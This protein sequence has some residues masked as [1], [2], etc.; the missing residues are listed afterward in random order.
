ME[1]SI[2]PSSKNAILELRVRQNISQLDAV[3]IFE[4]VFQRKIDVQHIPVDALQAKLNSF[5][6]S[7]QKSF[8]GLMKCV[9]S[10]DRIDMKKVLS[11]FPVELI[12]VKDLAILKLKISYVLIIF[13]AQF[14]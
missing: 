9:T 12:S 4:K 5:A 13:L 8:H 7:I 10:G 2:V 3:K 11:Q 14:K 1:S 6:D